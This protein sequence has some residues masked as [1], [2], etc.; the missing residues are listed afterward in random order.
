MLNPKT[1]GSL[2]SAARREVHWGYFC[3]FF[4]LFNWK[5]SGCVLGSLLVTYGTLF[6]RAGWLRGWHI[7]DVLQIYWQWPSKLPWKAWSSVGLGDGSHILPLFQCRT[8]SVPL[9]VTSCWHEGEKEGNDDDTSTLLNLEK[10]PHKDSVSF[11]NIS[12]GCWCCLV[13]CPGYLYSNFAEPRSSSLS[14]KA[15]L[16]VAL[17]N[18]RRH[19]LPLP[20]SSLWA[21]Y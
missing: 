18:Q 8:F 11:R 12:A 1:L 19:C 2:R 10:T 6:P 16:L 9:A 21:F 5:D 13:P 3:V 20:S 4:F 7:Q 15:V 14:W 17:Q